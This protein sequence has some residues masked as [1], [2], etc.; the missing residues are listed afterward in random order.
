MIEDAE[1]AATARV[2]AIIT[3]DEGKKFRTLAFYVSFETTN[4]PEQFQAIVRSFLEDTEA[5]K[6]T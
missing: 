6:N 2:K 1:D 3:S 5:G 4:T